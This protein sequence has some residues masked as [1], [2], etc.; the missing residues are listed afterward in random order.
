MKR[1]TTVGLLVLA[2]AAAIGIS[3][4]SIGGRGAGTPIAQQPVRPG[5]TPGAQNKKTD[6]QLACESI[7]NALAEFLGTNTDDV[8]QPD[9]CVAKPT[10]RHYAGHANLKFILATLPDPIHTQLPLIFDR[11]SEVIQYAAEDESY[12]YER[13]WLPWEDK[14]QTYSHVADQDLAGVRKDLQEKQPGI[15][16]FRSGSG[17][18]V[19][20]NPD[21]VAELEPYLDG[22]I[23]FVVGEDPTG[24][25]HSAQFK[26][27]LEWINKLRYLDR[28]N[29]AHIAILGPTFSGSFDSLSKLLAVGESGK[30]LGQIRNKSEVLAIYS[31]TANSGKAIDDFKGATADSLN[32]DFHNFLERD[33]V[34]LE[35]YCEYM[36][37][38]G[39][40]PQYIAILSEDE[41]AYGQQSTGKIPCLAKT[42]L[43]LYYPRDIS[44]LRTAYQT[45]SIFSPLTPQQG[46]DAGQR[47]LPTDLADP[48]GK[49]HDTIRSYA[50]S[51]T[52]LSQ[53]AYLF[54][55]VNVLKESKIETVIIRSTNALDQIFLARFLRRAYP[56]ARNVIDGADRLFEREHDAAG[57][58]GSIS[59]STY[60][61]LEIERQFVNAGATGHRDFSSDYSEGTY[62]A[63]RLLLHSAGMSEKPCQLPRDLKT[64]T[65][66]T[67]GSVPPLPEACRNSM[68]NIPLPDYGIPPWAITA[69]CAATKD[70][71]ETSRRPATTVAVLGRDGYWPIATINENTTIPGGRFQSSTEEISPPMPLGFALLVFSLLAVSCFHMWCSQRASFTAKPAFLGHFADP[72]ERRHIALIV[73]GSTF[74]AM[75]GLLASWGYGLFDT[76]SVVVRYP[77]PWLI[78]TGLI[79]TWTV[80][81]L[82]I[83]GN[84]LRTEI[85]GT[86]GKGQPVGRIA[87]AVLGLVFCVIFFFVSFVWPMSNQMMAA[88][89][90]FTYYR[91]LQVFSGVSPI[92]PFMALFL[93]FYAWFWQSLHGSA[94]FGPDRCVLPKED[95]LKIQLPEGK[96]ENFL[97]M[98]SHENAAQETERL[99]KPLNTPAVV[100]TLVAFMLILLIT[101]AASGGLP[102][103][104][105]GGRNNHASIFLFVLVAAIS[106]MLGETA[107]LLIVWMKLRELL[108]FLDRLPLRRTL[109]GLR[110]F[111]WGSVWG[112]SGNV[113]DVRY[114]LLSRQIESMGH[115]RKA[116]ETLNATHSS[117]SNEDCIESLKKTHDYGFEFARWY[118][119]KYSIRDEGDLKKLAEFQQSAA[120]S[121][122]ELLVHTLLPAWKEETNSLI[123]E[124]ASHSESTEQRIEVPPLPE[125][126]HIRDA[127]EFVCLPYLGFVQNILGRMRTLVMSTLLL[128]VA[129]TVA[130]SS[131]TF[132]PLQGL[133]GAML[134]L[135]ALLGIVILYVYMQMHRDATLSHITNTKP[136]EL[137]SD[138]W[139][140]LVGFGLAPLLGLLTTLFPGI[141][142]FVFSWIQPGLQSIK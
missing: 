88:N 47:R 1:G 108:R 141:A 42:K 103:R 80:A 121:S 122:A 65:S 24:G 140:K 116:L 68:N 95:D 11:M 32:I 23:V 55:V 46:T 69:D 30:S 14:E 115:T 73:L 64:S 70:V 38:Q 31:G 62:I 76:T 142:D 90:F 138:F 81:L 37:Q 9:S 10:D 54:G 41:T 43:W 56:D 53:E 16:L 34:G 117:Q 123:L 112:M 58:A 129:T 20:T 59:L 107:Q 110:G 66:L 119:D 61:L 92:V 106:L 4:P 83:L 85:L 131:Y 74:L 40:D 35:R 71:C 82:A 136:G 120:K 29:R 127:E 93:G 86:S 67:D 75:L 126:Q 109:A 133:G 118:A 135:F 124:E 89:T 3:L 137:G 99:A 63:F 8:P 45:N 91:S 98:F 22:L 84:V 36:Q 28:N 125:K 52:P 5:G 96:E 7:S 50:G 72:G 57:M 114:K 48:E 60:P 78:R 15:L 79:L 102:L 100:F 87:I 94:L 49:S 19:S 139:L 51:R 6:S 134:A 33:E 12:L 128:F 39:N 113:L 101:Y 18:S 25:I 17:P 111:S 2:I 13:S 97:R 26:N 44:A 105:L 130:I 21:N 77:Y 27:A 132:G 104:G